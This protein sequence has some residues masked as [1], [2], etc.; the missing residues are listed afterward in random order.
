MTVHGEYGGW[1]EIKGVQ[2][3]GVAG[4][5]RD[6]REERD[7]WARFLEKHPFVRELYP[8]G[9][10]LLAGLS[11]PSRKAVDEMARRLGSARMHRITVTRLYFIDNASGFGSRKEV[12]L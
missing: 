8:S 1:R 4:P 6:D 3:E 12:P 9:L 7:A 5:V 11:T 2:A 10:P